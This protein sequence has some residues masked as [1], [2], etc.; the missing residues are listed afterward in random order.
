VE[1][2]ERFPLISWSLQ[3]VAAVDTT[4]V[5]AVA[6]VGISLLVFQTS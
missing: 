4:Q 6:R 5:A 1:H 2:R 3:A